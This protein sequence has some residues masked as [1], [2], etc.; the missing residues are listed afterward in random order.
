MPVWLIIQIHGRFRCYVVWEVS[1]SEFDARG[2]HL[3]GAVSAAQVTTAD[4]RYGDTD[5]QISWRGRVM[6]RSP[7]RCGLVIRQ[8]SGRQ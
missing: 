7:I 1:R 8:A 3:E 5:D 2:R 4:S 6:S